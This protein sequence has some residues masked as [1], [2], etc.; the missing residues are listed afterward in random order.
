MTLLYKDF[1]MVFDPSVEEV[2][3]A[4]FKV[5]LYGCNKPLILRLIISLQE[6]DSFV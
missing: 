2:C 3:L 4:G 1:F 6:G 5:S